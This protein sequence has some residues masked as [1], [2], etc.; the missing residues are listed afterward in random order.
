MRVSVIVPTYKRPKSLRRCLDA[1]ARQDR[2]ADEIIVVARPEDAASHEVA[3]IHP[4]QVRTVPVER[5][6]VIAAMN[7][8]LDA[9]TGE[10]VAI[11][12]DDA[13]P[14]ADWV[15]RISTM[16]ASD[17]RIAA[18]GGR[19]WIYNDGRPKEGSERLVGV[20]KYFGRVTGNHHLGVGPSRDVDVLKGV[21][22]SVKGDLLRQI[23]FDE[24][25][26]GL[27]TENHWEL[28][29]CL[30]LRRLG[31]RVV[32]DPDIAVN[33]H[34]QPRVDDARQFGSRE[35]RA[36][37]HNETVAVLEHLPAWRRGIYL[38][39]TIAIGTRTAPGVARLIGSLRA[40]GGSRWSLFCG[41]QSGRILGLRTYRRSRHAAPPHAGKQGA[42][43][44]V[45]DARTS[46]LQATGDGPASS[47]AGDLADEAQRIW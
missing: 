46:Q 11:T 4:T 35:L 42:S 45:A 32:Y 5:S 25:L 38:A 13:E 7:A 2:P 18:V 24:R 36:S 22:L 47:T 20:I 3:R 12:D 37:T 40:P 14:H 41:A 29:L 26:L 10:V 8:G 19:D 15:Q 43:R 33:H 27:P 23:R 6:G 21:N 28:V 39:W 34:P 16:Y 9:S 1:L 31:L 17:S 30:T 44:H